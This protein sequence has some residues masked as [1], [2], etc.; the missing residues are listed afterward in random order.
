[1]LFEDL[2]VNND[3]KEG[4]DIYQTPKVVEINNKIA[5]YV[6]MYRYK[7]SR[8][9]YEPPTVSKP[10]IYTQANDFRYDTLETLKEMVSEMLEME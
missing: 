5:Q 7:P 4:E 1:M 3:V 6:E 10:G 8:L 9:I 2:S